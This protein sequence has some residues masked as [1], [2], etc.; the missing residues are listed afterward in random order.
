[1]GLGAYVKLHETTKRSDDAAWVVS[2]PLFDIC[3]M[4]EDNLAAGLQGLI[5]AW[6]NWACEF[7]NL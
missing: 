5:F 1:M 7:N 4:T 2:M 3:V 6:E